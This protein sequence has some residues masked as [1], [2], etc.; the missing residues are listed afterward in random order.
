MNSISVKGCIPNVFLDA[1]IASSFWG[2][3]IAFNRGEKYLIRAASGRGKSSLCSYLM[4]HRDDYSGSLL[5]DNRDVRDLSRDEWAEVRRD[6]IAYLPQ[7]LML[8]SDLTALE[9]IDIKNALTGFKSNEWIIDSLK[10]VGLAERL[11]KPVG[12]L[13]FGERQRVAAIRALCQ[14]FSF[15]IMDEPVSHLDDNTS[16][17][18][19]EII[20]EEVSS[21]GAGV[22]ATSIG[23]ELPFEYNHILNL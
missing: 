7:G 22:I 19:L 15:V 16:L 12:I 8:F 23:K 2:C 17:K 14:P 13:S 20:S 11:D 6:K 10:R 5:F 4:G 9:N 21:Q 18:V 3:D 1:N